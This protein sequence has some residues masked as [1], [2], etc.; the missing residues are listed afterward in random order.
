MSNTQEDLIELLPDDLDTLKALFK[1]MT[2]KEVQDIKAFLTQGVEFFDEEDYS[3]FLSMVD[4]RQAMILKACDE[5]LIE[6]DLEYKRRYN[7]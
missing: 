4:P 5:V 7:K 1:E 6:K 3:S 2:P